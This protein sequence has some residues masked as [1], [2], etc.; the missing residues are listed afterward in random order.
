M[1]FTGGTSGI[2]KGEK[3]IED[4]EDVSQTFPP[5]GGGV[6]PK[7]K[8]GSIFRPFC[9]HRPERK[10]NVFQSTEKTPTFEIYNLVWSSK[11]TILVLTVTG[12]K[13]E[14]MEMKTVQNVRRRRCRDSNPRL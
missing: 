14:K 8:I 5:P 12:I 13:R 4:P 7:A 1:L 10:K 9:I 11:E 3:G 6:F 2:K